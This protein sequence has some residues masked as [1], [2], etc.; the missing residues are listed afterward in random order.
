MQWI[1][2]ALACL[3]PMIW[4]PAAPA[5]TLYVSP[6]GNDHWSGQLATP[7]Q[8]GSDGPLASL[9]GARNALRQMK[10]AGKRTGPVHVHIA[11]GT[12]RQW[13]PTVFSAE[14]SGTKDA[15]IIYEAAPGAKPV[16]DAGRRITH[17]EV[18]RQGLWVADLPDVGAGKWYF[19]QLFVNGRWAVRARSPNRFYYHVTGAL[20][21][22]KDPR[23]GQP[24]D[25]TR[26][27][28]SGRKADLQQVLALPD[29][30]LRDVA[31]VVYHSW[32]T[33]RHRIAAVDREKAIAY[34]TGP[35]P[36][37]FLEWGAEQ[38]YHLE[39][40]FAALDEPGE[41]FL[42][43]SGKLYYK[44]LPAEDPAKAHVVAPIGQ[45]FLILEGQPEKGN[46]VEY[47]AFRG[48]AFRHS[49]SILPPEGHGDSQAASS[50]PA[51]I[52]V[53]G[54]RNIA[55]EDCEVEHVGL[56]GVWFRRG[57]QHCLVAGC[58]LHHLGA[59]GVRIGETSIRTDARERT[60][61]VRVEN[62]IIRAGGLI[63]T[64]AV[65]VWIGQSGDNQVLHND[66]SD[67]FYTGVSVGWTWGY[68]PSLA[69]N[70]RIEFNRIHHLGRGVLSDLGG[71]YTLGVSPGTTVS[72]NVIHDVDS[73][74][75]YGRGGWGLYNDE[76][77]TGIVQENN[78]VYNTKTGGYHQHYGRDNVVR[79][80]IFAFSRDGQLQRSRVEAHRSF[81]F[82]HNIVYWKG[83][84]LFSGS[85]GDP[86]VDL[87][88]NLYFE[89]SGQ[90]VHFEGLSLEEWQ[91]HGKDAG[92]IVADPRFV[93]PD[94]FDFRLAA[95]SPA[96]KIGFRPFD[97]SRAGLQRP[98]CTSPSGEE[99][100]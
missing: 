74:D 78:L 35:A 8:D 21:Q 56:Y 94:R 28:F 30:Q 81:W 45:Q 43:R 40:L 31:V 88:Q 22:A 15:P 37:P 3:L 1:P 99:K 57:C 71:V 46:F 26:R 51:V 20:S 7:K 23:T 18:N 82:M 93:A 61:H 34:L 13:E 90:T 38:R 54:A 10:T 75:R 42:D 9:E 19:E 62:N 24:A 55:I 41:W 72:N 4:G 2:V 60:G 80:N 65:G 49:G 25:W 14:D 68:G 16:F 33:S 77:S 39:N 17:F 6:Q 48:L 85:W 36:W 96:R 83:G 44:P 58:C 5:S 52:Q 27:A 32:E 70:N 91:K 66:I 50:V 47:L 11:A 63:F 76:G 69:S 59:G 79:N 86:H 100:P 89:A 73:Y 92:S 64:G 84:R 53:D 95:D 97:P 29:A 12:Y 98:V 67:L 87:T